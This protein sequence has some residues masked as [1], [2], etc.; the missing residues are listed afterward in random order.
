[1]LE[2]G[3][4]EDEQSPPSSTT[5][6]RIKAARPSC[7]R[8][9]SD[10]GCA[11]RGIVE[12]CSDTYVSQSHPGGIARTDYIQHLK[13]A[14]DEVIRVSLAD[15]L[16]NARAILGDYRLE[17]ERLWSRFIPDAD[18]LWYYRALANAFRLKTSS[19]MLDELERVIEQLELLMAL[20][21]GSP[22]HPFERVRPWPTVPINHVTIHA[23]AHP[24]GASARREVKARDANVRLGTGNS[25][26]AV[27]RARW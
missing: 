16:H 4:D 18:Q 27:P 20:T 15:K 24:S 2:D 25:R 12:G 22:E 11:S 3:G 6:S 10:L 23:E 1:M 8:F 5:W 13:D 7:A 19:P 21:H 17:G 26:G 14:P 9:A